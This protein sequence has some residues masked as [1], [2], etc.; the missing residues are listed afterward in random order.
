VQAILEFYSEWPPEFLESRRAFFLFLH[1]AYN[2]ALGRRPASSR[3]LIVYPQHF[4]NHVMASQFIDDFAQAKFIH[5]IRDPITLCG[6]MLA[7]RLLPSEPPRDPNETQSAANASSG[8]ERGAPSEPPGAKTSF[9]TAAKVCTGTLQKLADLLR[10]R[11][12]HVL[13]P[14]NGDRPHFG[15]ESRTR[16]IRFEDLHCDTAETMRD[17]SDWLGLPYQST[18]LQSTFNGIPWVVKRDG[19]TWSGRRPEQAQR[20]LR[21]ISLKDRGLLFALFYKNFANWNYPHPRIFRHALVRYAIFFTLIPF[22]LKIEIVAARARF[23]SRILPA[24]RSGNI[25][26]AVNSLLLILSYRLVIAVLFVLEFTGRCAHGKTLLEF[27]HGRDSK[28]TPQNNWSI[29]HAREFD[30]LARPIGPNP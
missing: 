22:P 28:G 2:L 6:Q 8:A 20:S 10:R 17:L 15:M 5:T 12:F 9:L 3:P 23:K 27:G 7:D 30:G 1:I 4:W 13:S 25:S 18:L 19:I 21:Y 11:R 26:I 29:D 16:A 14:I 24:L